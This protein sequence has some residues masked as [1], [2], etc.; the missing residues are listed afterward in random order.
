MGAKQPIL[1]TSAASGSKAP[2]LNQHTASLN[3]QASLSHN[4]ELKP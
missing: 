4:N 3:Q 1:K 2:G